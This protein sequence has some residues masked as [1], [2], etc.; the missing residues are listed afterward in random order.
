M[1]PLRYSI[2]VTLDGCC[3]HR[4]MFADQDLHRHAVENLDQA[5]ALLFGRVTYEMMEAAPDAFVGV[6]RLFQSPSMV[7]VAAA[8]RIAIGIVLLCAVRD[9]RLPIFLHIFGVVYRTLVVDFP[10]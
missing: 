8:L 6:V 9:S 2:N 1:R 3:D 10:V 7:Y 5:D 4:A